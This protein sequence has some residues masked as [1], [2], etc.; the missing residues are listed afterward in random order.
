M[1]GLVGCGA[2]GRFILRDLLRLGC[3]VV[4]ADP[5]AESRA[6]AVRAGASAARPGLDELPAGLAGLV[7]ATPTSLHAAVIEGLLPRGVPLFVEKP[8]TADPSTAQD[9]ARRAG[10]RLFVMDKWRYHP[11]VE[12]IAAIVRSGELGPLRRL[13]TL[14]L[15]WRDRRPDLD[16]V[17]SLLPHD[18]AIALEILGQLPEPVRATAEVAAGV[19]VGMTAVLGRQPELLVQVS[20]RHPAVRRQIVV[21]CGGGSVRL[22]AADADH[23]LVRRHGAGPAAPP[24]RRPIGGAPPLEREL[25]AFLAHLRGGPPPRGSAAEG[26]AAVAAIARLLELAGCAA[27]ASAPQDAAA[28]DR[29][30]TQR[31]GQAP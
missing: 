16:A 29:E 18:L 22:A 13:S 11:G 31:P 20:D 19:V 3:R 15:G 25:A 4:V 17:W 5:A 12:A 27:G 10:D 26:A 6:H 8:L 30:P 28:A 23:L 7:V 24:E 9:L 2:W 21:D 14:R 1:I